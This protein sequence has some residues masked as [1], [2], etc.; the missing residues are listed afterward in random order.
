MLTLLTLLLVTSPALSA[1]LNRRT[2]F[3]DLKG[4]LSWKRK[5]TFDDEGK[6]KVSPT[7]LRL[8]W[9]SSGG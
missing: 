9:H 5:L 2:S 7:S 4:V 1:P 6:F 3:S 8:T